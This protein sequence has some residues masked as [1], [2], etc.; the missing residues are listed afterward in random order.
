MLAV[1]IRSFSCGCFDFCMM[2]M[3]GLNVND[4]FLPFLRLPRKGMVTVGFNLFIRLEMTT[5]KEAHGL[6]G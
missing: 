2:L 4:I 1:F 6:G 3:F 5:F